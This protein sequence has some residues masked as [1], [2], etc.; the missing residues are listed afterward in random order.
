[1]DS[2]VPADYRVKIKENEKRDKY[3]DLARELKTTTQ[4][5]KGDGETNCNRCTR[6][7][8]QKFVKGTGRIRNQR[9]TEDHPNCSIVKIGQNTE[10]GSGD[11]R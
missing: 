6:N 11:L 5:H 3:V 9:T 7:N 4:G 1:M 8:P 10:K 2:A